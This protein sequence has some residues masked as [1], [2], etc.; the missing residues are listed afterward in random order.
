MGYSPLQ[1]EGKGV[2]IVEDPILWTTALAVAIL[3]VCLFFFSLKVFIPPCCT[4]SATL[5]GVRNCTSK[6]P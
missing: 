4:N 6:H 2:G 3:Q 1:L 5:T